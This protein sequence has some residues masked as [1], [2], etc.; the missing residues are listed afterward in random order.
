MR[1]ALAVSLAC[2]A[3]Y[4]GAMA[5]GRFPGVWL[6]KALSIAVLAWLVRRSGVLVAAVLLGAT[7]DAL[8][9]LGRQWFL[10]GLVAFLCGHVAY[11]VGFLRLPAGRA[12]ARVAL[13]ALAAYGI[14]FYA[15]LWPGLASMRAPV[16]VYTAAILAMTM[17]SLRLG[18]AVTSG[19][20]LFLISDS[21]L[22]A[23]RFHAPMPL[24]GPIV[25]STYYFGQF[26]IVTGLAARCGEPERVSA[27][28]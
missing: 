20:L 28:R 23:N 3:A 16:A 9:S 2:S 15:W 19:A 27:A 10:H 18:G 4:A 24:S 22:A 13:V 7:G 12:P 26:L 5:W 17:A 1:V 25:W 11:A 14:A 8:L 6:V 21:V